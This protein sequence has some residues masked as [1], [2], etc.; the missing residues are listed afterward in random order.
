MKTHTETVS[1]DD[2]GLR[3]AC[4]I[5]DAIFEILQDRHNRDISYVSYD[6]TVDFQFKEGDAP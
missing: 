4:Y 6:I 1:I 5:T 3:E 2:F